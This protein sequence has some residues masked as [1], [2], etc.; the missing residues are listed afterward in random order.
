[1]RPPALTHAPTR[2]PGPPQEGKN[3]EIREFIRE[4]TAKQER[5][6]E[7][8]RGAKLAAAAPPPPPPPAPPPAPQPQP[9]PTPK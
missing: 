4:Q 7:E 8:A 9:P 2:A 1:M 3:E 5:L 6:L